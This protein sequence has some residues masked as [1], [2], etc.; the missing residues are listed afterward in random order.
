MTALVLATFS[1][2]SVVAFPLLFSK[3]LSSGKEFS[4]LKYSSK[5]TS[6]Q[7][8]DPGQSF[9]IVTFSGHLILPCGLVSS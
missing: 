4:L 5:N 3:V 6:A 2:F 7:S 8:I 9:A 1:L